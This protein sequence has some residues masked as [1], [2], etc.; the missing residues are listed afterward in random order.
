MSNAFGRIKPKSK[1][2]MLAFE[3][4]KWLPYN[5]PNLDSISIYGQDRLKDIAWMVSHCKTDSLREGIV[6]HLREVTSLIIDIFGKCGD[7]AHKLPPETTKEIRETMINRGKVYRE[8]LKNYKFYLSFE[9]SLCQD[10]ITEKFFLA[11]YAGALPV[12]Y[13]GLSKSD[14]DKVAPPH[15]FI[16]VDDFDTI[17]DLSKHLT[18]L[19]NNPEAYSS[20]F[21]WQEHY[22]VLSV[23]DTQWD[24]FCKLCE[25]LNHYKNGDLDT[26]A[27]A[28]K[29]EEFHKYWNA[30]GVC[31]PPVGRL[32]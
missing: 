3:R 31:R 9:N 32:L 12:A 10:Y 28:K 25:A 13:G 7:K 1:E 14:Y 17:E 29:Y 30:P 2:A 19:S 8:K 21:W 20:Y 26:K 15:S 24:S 27:E 4:G 5:N 23:Y 6:T 22:E 16:H 18:H 11:M